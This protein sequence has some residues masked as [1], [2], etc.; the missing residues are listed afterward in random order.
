MAS[1]L[2]APFCPS[3]AAE[4]LRDTS[5]VREDV[6]IRPYRE[7][8]APALYEAARESVADVFPWLAWCHSSYTIEEARDWTRTRA[9]L[10]GEGA[11]Y[12]FVITDAAERF[13]GGCG[14]NQLNREHRL[15][16]LGYWV[17]T[18]AAGQGVAA[19][20][21][22]RVAAFAFGST[23]LVRLE[24]VCA[25]A[26]ERSQRAAEK[27]GATREGTLR[28]RLRIHGRCHDAVMY[29]IVKPE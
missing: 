3:S 13:L 11:E 19:A 28:Q 6:A 29:S 23:D 22:R 15:A 1:P 18:S 8:D 26:N 27:G 25:V 7:T 24:I 10:F 21:V 4:V 17:R 16:N 2:T 20:A 9:K 5:A 12:N 14:L